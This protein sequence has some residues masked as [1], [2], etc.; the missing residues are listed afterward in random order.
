MAEAQV[1]Q[2]GLT[3]EQAAQLTEAELRRLKAATSQASDPSVQA[4]SPLEAVSPEA[5]GDAGDAPIELP[6]EQ[7][8]VRS[9]A[10]IDW[11]ATAIQT[12]QQ[13]SAPPPRRRDPIATSKGNA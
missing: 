5:E 13:E 9:P 4:P 6:A 11:L 10:E 1:R 8:F 2:F 3:P 7:R 12:L